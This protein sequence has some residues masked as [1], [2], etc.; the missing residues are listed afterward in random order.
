MSVLQS[1]LSSFV[2][3]STELEAFAAALAEHRLVTV[4]G[5]GG[6]GKTRLAQ[7]VACRAGAR[8]RDGVRLVPLAPVSTREGLVAAMTAV[9]QADTAPH[10]GGEFD[11]LETAIGGAEV[12]LL[13][14]NCEHLRVEVAA[15]V[16]HLMGSC[17]SLTVLATSREPLH[18]E[19]E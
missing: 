17:P 3:R 12:L 13:L 7:E 4:T 2:G 16:V 11:G 6:C 8:Y 18:L 14:D 5:V 10:R 9:V 1:P 15:V 19:G